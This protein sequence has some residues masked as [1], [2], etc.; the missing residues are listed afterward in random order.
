MIK[1]IAGMTAPE[2]GRLPPANSD[3]TI[4]RIK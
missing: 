1:K 2:K 4:G 3:E